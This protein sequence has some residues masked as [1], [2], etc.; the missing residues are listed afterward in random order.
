MLFHAFSSTS[1]VLA[2]DTPSSDVP[3]S[4]PAASENL[5]AEEAPSPVSEY[6]AAYCDVDELPENVRSLVAQSLET[7]GESTANEQKIYL[8]SAQDAEIPAEEQLNQLRIEDPATGTGT[9]EIY[10]V[11]IK[12]LDADGKVRFIDTS[13]T[14]VPAVL[15]VDAE[16]DAETDYVYQNAA[17]AFRTLFARTADDGVQ[18]D[19]DF[20]LSVADPCAQNAEAVAAEEENGA[21]KVRYP[22]AF[23]ADTAVE[24]V[25]TEAGVK[26][27]IVLNSN[28]GRNRFDFCFESET[29]VPMLT[30]DGTRAYVVDKNNPDEIKYWFSSI[31]AYDSWLPED[32]DQPQGDFRHFNEEGVYELAPLGENR[33]KLT[34]VV[35]AEY[36]NHPALVYPVTIDP[37]YTT[38]AVP[39]GSSVV[40]D[41][42]FDENGT[43]Y[44][45]DYLR[46]GN[47][48][49]GTIDSY[50]RFDSF[51]SY[52][53]ASAEIIDATMILK[54]RSGQTTGDNG[55]LTQ[56]TTD[57]SES[58]ASR[59]GYSSN[60]S[61]TVSKSYVNSYI[62][63]YAVDMYEFARKWRTGYFPNYG[64]RLTYASSMLDYNSIVSSDG[65]AARAPRLQV[66]YQTFGAAPGIESGS[67]YFIKNYG[68]STTRKY[69][70]IT[71]NSTANGATAQLYSY[72]GAPSECWQ[73]TYLG[74]GYYSIRTM[75]S[76]TVK[77]LDGRSNCV[78]GAQVIIYDYTTHYGELASSLQWRIV[79][80]TNGS[81]QFFPKRNS[82][83]ALSVSGTT[84]TNNPAVKL[85]YASSASIQQWG[86]EKSL[87]GNG[88]EYRQINTEKPNCFGY[89]MKMAENITP[90]RPWPSSHQTED[91]SDLIKET[92]ENKAGVSCRRIE[93]YVA[94]IQE[95]EYRV[96]VRF[97]NNLNNNG[98]N[99]HLIYQLSDGTWA[100]K[101]NTST[102]RH[103]D[104]LGLSNPSTSSEMWSYN[105]YSESAGTIY[106]AVTR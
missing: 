54:F 50:I 32:P 8:S 56:V 87:F 91:F 88:G 59:P 55:K 106:F 105:A 26:E 92:M 7:A 48:A 77:M 67:L 82:E 53:P 12:Y 16:V 29:C 83:L 72:A 38:T 17:N 44:N 31:Y 70:D 104:N 102:S 68:A 10:S 57:W 81:Y 33:W 62:D 35:P 40:S 27:N 19:G 47:T 90:N 75:L 84:S 45:T 93:S 15:S 89:A 34:V 25:N 58:S 100:G 43:R 65:E 21:G 80:Q 2:A 96:A 101:D 73:L 46:F 86:L 14:P 78:A 39:N 9:M 3:S 103:F 28:I 13:L 95:N 30:E 71:A 36:L 23:G 94:H 69:L 97:P 22:G 11:P 52:I 4:E 37:S 99:Y 42:F 79:R 64:V 63:H 49:G 20:R 76:N 5:T 1:S 6:D 98:Y 18:A 51:S 60:V 24:Y 85:D 74:N 41:V 66:T 61:V